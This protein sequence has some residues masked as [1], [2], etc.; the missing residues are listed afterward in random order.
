MTTRLDTDRLSERY[1][2]SMLDVATRRIL[3]ARLA[4]SDQEP[5]LS[6]PP[7]ADGCG[8][9]RHFHRNSGT[10]WV[11]NPLPIDPAR[12][13]LGLPPGDAL[14]SEVFQNGAC[15]WR[16]WYCF[17]PFNMLSAIPSR[18]RWVTADELVALYAALPDRP[19]MLDLSGGQ[20]DL[21]PEWVLWTMDA[22]E[23]S[24][25]ASSVYLWSD[26]N[27]SND[28]FFRYLSDAERERIAKYRMY[29]RVGCFK[30]FDP[31]SFAFNT[32]ADPDLYPRQFEVFGRL[33][34]LGLDLYAY[35]TFT[36]PHDSDVAGRMAHFVDQLQQV[37]E[38]LPLRTVPLQIAPFGPV[39]PR[40]N[41]VKS[42]AISVG[43]F[44]ALEAWRVELSRRFSADELRQP[45]NAVRW[46]R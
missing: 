42:G 11:P 22:L 9:V 8:R 30:G 7:N 41:S 34:A 15:N 6:E 24:D 46:S 21:T 18:S 10:G 28:Y 32:A 29:G 45:I 20:P 4:G 31:E 27:L 38:A 43:Q 33:L 14:N 26:D 44:K 35:V 40:L 5:D 25:L 17:V 3:I 37:D 36:H 2:S 19:P 1:R 12:A 23:R 39:G 16:C 13:A